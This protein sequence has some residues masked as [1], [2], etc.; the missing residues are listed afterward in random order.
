MAV[1]VEDE[2]AQLH[3]GYQMTHAGGWEQEYCVL[4]ACPL[5]DLGVL[6]KKGGGG[7]GVNGLQAR[8]KI[9][10]SMIPLKRIFSDILLI[11]SFFFLLF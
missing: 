7:E 8:I 2:L 9:S 1:L 4:H 6:L 3:H 5:F 11:F 10:R